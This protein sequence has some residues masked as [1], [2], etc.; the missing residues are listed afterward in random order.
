MTILN[1]MDGVVERLEETL[2]DFPLNLPTNDTTPFKI[3]RHKV[4]ERLNNKFDYSKK[5]THDE[6]YPFC[7]VKIDRG[8]KEENITNQDTVLNCIIGV[9]NEGQNGEGYD[10]VI[11]CIQSIW[12]D[13]NKDPVIAK[14]HKIKYDIEWAVDDNDEQTHPFYYGIIRLTIESPSMQ[15]L[16][17]NTRGERRY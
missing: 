16:G 13:F 4:P 12:N 9:K 6:V 3:F 17:G 7:V 14:F 1:I 2:K 5:D 11:T 15:F 8:K 10:D